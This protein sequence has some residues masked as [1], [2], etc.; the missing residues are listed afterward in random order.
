[1]IYTLFSTLLQLLPGMGRS[2]GGLFL[3][4]VSGGLN[5]PVKIHSRS[6]LNR[7]KLAPSIKGGERGGISQATFKTGLNIASKS[8]DPGS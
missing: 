7:F 1:M 2:L 6:R 5:K 4:A 8:H 3:A